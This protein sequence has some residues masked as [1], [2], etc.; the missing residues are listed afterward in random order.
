MLIEA[1]LF[2]FFALALAYFITMLNGKTA[3]YKG[4]SDFYELSKPGQIVLDSTELPW[5]GKTA[6]L[7]FAIFIE[8]AP[9]TL[10][11][12]DCVDDSSFQ[13]VFKPSCSDYSF[14]PCKCSG[15]SCTTCAMTEES[16][17]M[18]KLLSIGSVFELWTSGYTSTNDK[19][20]VSTLL[21]IQTASSSTQSYVEGITLPAIPLQRWTVITIVKEGRRYD[22]FYGEKLVASSLCAYVPLIP[23]SG[24]DWKA[25]TS[26][27][28]WKGKI[29]LFN[30]F[31]K[32][33][34]QDDVHAD[35][36]SLLN[37]RGIPFHLENLKFS[38]DVNIPCLLG[39]CNTLPVVKP[40]NPFVAFHSNFQ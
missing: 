13:T 34:S 12:V 26:A 38:F 29:G 33:Q 30:G 36:S 27:K 39:N 20:Y 21:K 35:V 6:S 2:I 8:N 10:K 14:K 24:S 7:R 18:S 9:K 11:K 19:P 40:L 31:S 3:T 16:S 37:T 25:G 22:V 1:I 15:I 23:S 5:T 17:Y 28:G 32:A 4:I